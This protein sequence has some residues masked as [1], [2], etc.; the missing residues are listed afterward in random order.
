VKIRHRL[1][2]RLLVAMVSIGIGVLVFTGIATVG[3]TRR[4]TVDV[5]RSDLT[6]RAPAVESALIALRSRADNQQDRAQIP[7]A[8]R[9]ARSEFLELLG[10]ALQVADGSL[11]LLGPDGTIRPT[12]TATTTSTAPRDAPD[13]ADR[14][15]RLSPGVASS[16]LDPEPL[17]AGDHQTGQSG[18]FVFVAIPFAPEPNGDIPVV[19]LT[20]QI[21]RALAGRAGPFFLGTALVAAVAAVA[22]SFLLARRFTRPLATMSDT[23][24]RIATGDLSA[25]VDVGRMPSDEVGDLADTLNRM[26]EQLETARG[27][28][29]LFLLSVSHDLRTPLTSIRGY[30]EAISDGTA[31]D[32]A[33]LERA[34]VVISSESRRLERLV[35]DLLQLADLDA[36]QFS[37]RPSRFDAVETV[38]DAVDAF[39]PAATE[40]G[41]ELHLDVPSSA[42][43]NGDPERLGQIVANLVENALAYATTHIDVRVTVDDDLR[44]LVSDDGPGIASAD[45]ERVFERLYSSRGARG[46][47]VGTGLGLAIVRELAG[48]MGGAVTVE[49]DPGGGARFT[50]RLPTQSPGAATG[51][52]GSPPAAR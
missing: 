51:R 37:L 43:V 30:A 18:D 41:M 35:A 48:A 24:H 20:N 23:A 11:A 6:E 44:V 52:P 40:G 49:S 1:R 32:P 3:L 42:V 16:D 19:V 5:V 45:I 12:I 9:R 2:K 26:A 10:T 13:P 14:L 33:M 28:E 47:A 25:R 36:R 8:Q 50:V 38:R 7:E 17:R 15:R 34:A 4:T 22:I 39:Q 31:S 29:R 27:Q 46:R 21:E